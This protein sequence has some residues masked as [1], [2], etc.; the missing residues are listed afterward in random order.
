L[1]S[2]IQR[3]LSPGGRT[4]VCAVASAFGFHTLYSVVGYDFTAQAQT[5]GGNDSTLAQAQALGRALG[6]PV[7][8]IRC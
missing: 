3:Y 5:H 1:H 6:L 7:T 2:D 8:T 4:A